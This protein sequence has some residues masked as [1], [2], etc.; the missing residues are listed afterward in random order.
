MKPS[1][2]IYKEDGKYLLSAQTLRRLDERFI[3][4]GMVLHI[5]DE[6]IIRHPKL[7]M[8]NDFGELLEEVKK[9]LISATNRQKE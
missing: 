3:G 4:R 2:F 9:D 5:I 6:W 7:L 1:E 8:R